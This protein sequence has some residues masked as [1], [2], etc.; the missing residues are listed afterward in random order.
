MK[1][2]KT[3]KTGQ[4]AVKGPVKRTIT[5]VEAGDETGVNACPDSLAFLSALYCLSGKVIYRLI[6]RAPSPFPS[7]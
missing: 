7:M 2:T 3:A 6:R 5:A 4:N 1:G